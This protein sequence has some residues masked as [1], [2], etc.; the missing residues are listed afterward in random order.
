MG[1]LFRMISPVYAA[2]SVHSISSF[3]FVLMAE[4][5]SKALL[6]IASGILI[7]HGPGGVQSVLKLTP[8]SSSYGYPFP[9]KKSETNT[10]STFIHVKSGFPVRL[11]YEKLCGLPLARFRELNWLSGH[12]K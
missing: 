4:L 3:P 6:K 5:V 12:C 11:I 10:S 7:T 9:H 8:G 2:A 1:R